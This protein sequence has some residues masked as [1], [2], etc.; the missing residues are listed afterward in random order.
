MS[1]Q[2][3][4]AFQLS[5]NHV[6]KTASQTV[7]FAV[8]AAISTLAIR[9]GAVSGARDRP[10]GGPPLKIVLG[11]IFML[12]AYCSGAGRMDL[13]PGWCRRHPW[14]SDSDFAAR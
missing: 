8:L 6:L 11:V 1:R 10:Q 13:W 12:A 3:R 4:P 7:D 2:P 9:I 5:T 14:R